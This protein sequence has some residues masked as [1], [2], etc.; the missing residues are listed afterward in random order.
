MNKW[1]FRGLE[2]I[3]ASRTPKRLEEV[4]VPSFDGFSGVNKSLSCFIPKQ[5]DTEGPFD[6]PSTQ[7]GVD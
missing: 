2:H 6:F 4:I 1:I 7:C 5:V 3:G